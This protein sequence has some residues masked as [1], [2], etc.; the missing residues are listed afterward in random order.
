VRR[1]QTTTLQTSPMTEAVRR[2]L[3]TFVLLA[4]LVW[5]TVVVPAPAGAVFVRRAGGGPADAEERDADDDAP[6]LT[7]T[8]SA[9][10]PIE[11]LDWPDFING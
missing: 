4:V 2:R 1:V 5:Y 3:L 8:A 6:A 9:D 7:T 11:D 10:T